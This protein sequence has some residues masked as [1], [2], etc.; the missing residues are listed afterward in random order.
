MGKMQRTKGATFEREIVKDLVSRGF[1]DAKRNLEQTREGGGDIN[2]PAHLIECKRYAK[3]AVYQWL[4]QATKAAKDHQMPVVVAR[5]DHKKAIA[6]LYWD[7]FLGMM[8]NA[9]TLT[10]PYNPM[11]ESDQAKGSI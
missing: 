10:K 11:V 6:I 2:L 4:D 9:E 1:D 7:D 8:D 3:I 5:A